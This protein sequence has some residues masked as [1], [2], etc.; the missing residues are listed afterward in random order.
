MMLV[1]NK[2]DRGISGVLGSYNTTR[3]QLELLTC[4]AKLVK[5]GKPVTQKD[6][7]DFVRQDKTTVSEVMKTLEKKGYITRSTS[8]GDMRVKYITL[9]DKGFRLVKTAAF[10]VMQFDEQFFP[11]N[12]DSK[13]LKRLLKKYL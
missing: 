3:T 12:S 2:W 8:E 10:E 11:D 6:V 4:I 7:V 5:D 13:E 1:Q 9:T